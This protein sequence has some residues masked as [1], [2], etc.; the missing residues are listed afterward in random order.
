MTMQTKPAMSA[1]ERALALRSAH[2]TA[3]SLAIGNA[4][5]AA[6]AKMIWKGLPTRARNRRDGGFSYKEQGRCL[7]VVAQF[8]R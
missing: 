5:D 7:P 1:Q 4:W 2:H 8:L 6:S 3:R